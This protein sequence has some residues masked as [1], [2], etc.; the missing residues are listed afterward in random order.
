MNTIEDNVTNF[1][2]DNL[3]IINELNPKKVIFTHI[4]ET[5]GL[6]FDDFKKLEQIY[7]NFVFA[8]DGMNIDI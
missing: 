2:R 1:Q 8:Y 5:D 7:N 3:R 4:E 6:S